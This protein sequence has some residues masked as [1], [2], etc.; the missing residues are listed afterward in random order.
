MLFD[1]M[2][3]DR[4]KLIAGSNE[5]AKLEEGVHLEPEQ[6]WMVKYPG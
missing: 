4:D 1:W 3:V 2:Y 5:L 6:A